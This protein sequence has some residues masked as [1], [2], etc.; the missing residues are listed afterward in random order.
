MAVEPNEEQFARV[1]KL[2]AGEPAGPVVMLNLKRY[3]AL[4]A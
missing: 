3:R 2:A 1:A 4:D